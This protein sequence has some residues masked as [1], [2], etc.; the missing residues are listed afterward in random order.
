MGVIDI[1]SGEEIA[2]IPT[3]RRIPHGVVL[4]PDSRFAF[5]TCEDKG[6]TPGSV[7]AI[8]LGSLKRVS[9]V[10]V[11]LQAGGVALF[12]KAARPHFSR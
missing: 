5:I 7:D 4:T 6:A 8:D 2:R 11:G 10:D 3:S 12:P 9:T 1:A